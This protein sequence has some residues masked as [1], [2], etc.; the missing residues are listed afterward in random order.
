MYINSQ[1]TFCARYWGTWP[2]WPVQSHKGSCSGW[3]VTAFTLESVLKVIEWQIHRYSQNTKAETL[4]L[5]F[6]PSHVNF[7][8]EN[9]ILLVNSV[10][11]RAQERS[12]TA[13]S[14]LVLGQYSRK[15][16]TQCKIHNST[17]P[18]SA[19]Y[20]PSCMFCY[21]CLRFLASVCLSDF[22][23][24]FF[25]EISN[26]QKDF[27]FWFCHSAC[28]FSHQG[29]SWFIASTHVPS[30]HKCIL[31]YSKLLQSGEL[32]ATITGYHDLAAS[33]K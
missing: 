2:L 16:S 4:Q 11:V 31:N 9:H 15:T 6:C 26:L 22:S 29:L 7:F 14:I 23:H 18:F 3:N 30:P 27:D 13:A 28:V 5:H 33:V 17:M 19:Y 20:Y 32:L 12:P 1:S 21:S 10:P 8:Q 24:F 25:P